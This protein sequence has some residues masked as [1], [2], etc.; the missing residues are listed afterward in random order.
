MSSPD[1]I[2]ERFDELVR[3]LRAGSVRVGASPELRERVRAIAEREPEPP[4]ARFRLPRRRW[5]LVESCSSG[6]C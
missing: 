2:D 3:E 4:P 5:A 6:P 1:S